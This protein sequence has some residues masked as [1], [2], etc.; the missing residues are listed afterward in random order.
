MYGREAMEQ[1]RKNGRVVYLKISYETMAARLGDYRH[2]GVVMP[3]GYTL[4]DV[5]DERAV[6][7]EKYADLVLEEAP[8]AGLGDTLERLVAILQKERTKID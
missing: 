8:D 5:Y 4:R 1:L 3:R 6:L 7:Y 2:R